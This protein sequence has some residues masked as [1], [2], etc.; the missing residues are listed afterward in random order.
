MKNSQNPRP[1]KIG[2]K[3]KPPGGLLG[4][5]T[6]PGQMYPGGAGY[7]GYRYRYRTTQ[8]LMHMQYK[9]AAHL[10]CGGINI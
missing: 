5:T 7:P 1:P 9:F 6:V 8:R 2:K 3:F 4:E 10:S